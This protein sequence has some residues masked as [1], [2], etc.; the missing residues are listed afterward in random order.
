[1]VLLYRL[2]VAIGLSTNAAAVSLLVFM[3]DHT[4]AVDVDM[5]VISGALTNPFHIAT[6]VIFC[7]WRVDV[8]V[9]TLQADNVYM[10]VSDSN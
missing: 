2:L 10:C 7:C 6:I 9:I 3:R 8:I 1:M 4:V 5:C